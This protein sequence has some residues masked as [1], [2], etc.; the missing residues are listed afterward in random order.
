MF[1]S[2][3]VIDIFVPLL[4]SMIDQN[5][6]DVFYCIMNSFLAI[7][8]VDLIEFGLDFFFKFQYCVSKRTLCLA[9]IS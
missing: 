6:I 9:F 5:E 1:I 8:T 2:F 4:F 3:D 7:L